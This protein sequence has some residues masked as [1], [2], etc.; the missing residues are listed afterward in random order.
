MVVH[1]DDKPAQSPK[2]N[3]GGGDDNKND[4]KTNS[5]CKGSFKWRISVKG[6]K[7]E[8]VSSDEELCRLMYLLNEIPKGQAI[9]SLLTTTAL[10]LAT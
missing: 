3:G 6:C 2:Y 5:A 9:V 1:K 4:S 7:R 8:P 10:W